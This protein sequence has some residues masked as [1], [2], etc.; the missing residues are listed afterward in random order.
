VLVALCAVAYFP[1]LTSQGLTNWQESARALAAR[2]MQDRGD[3]VVPTIDGRPYLAKP[4]MFYWYQ[5]ALGLALGGRVGELELR[6]SAALAGTA[7]VLATYFAGRRL[8][9]SGSGLGGS[10]DAAS[11]LRGAGEERARRG[12]LWGSAF[13]ATGILY[14][15]SSRVGELDIA[16]VAWT[17]LGVWGIF[18][19]WRA[20]R[21]GARA[22]W[23][24]LAALGCAGA[25]LTKGPVGL[26]VP[27]CAGFGGIVA[28]AA[29]AGRGASGARREARAGSGG[30][31]RAAAAG[32]W[33]ANPVVVM[34]SGVAALWAWGRG[35]EAR[36][37]SAE[38]VS[39]AAAMEAG[40]NL[41]LLS[42]E[43]VLENLESLSFGAGAGSVGMVLALIWL[44]R[45]RPTL[46]AGAWVVVLWVVASAVVFTVFGRGSPRYLTPV[47]PGVAL[48]AGMWMA[49]AERR[50]GAGTAVRGAGVA[51]VVTLAIVQGWWYGWG[52]ARYDGARSPRA[53]MGELL[54]PGLGVDRTA[55]HALDFWTP[56]LAFYADAPVVPVHLDGPHID[57]PHEEMTFA[58]F[59]RRVE[60][61]EGETVTLLVRASAAPGTDGAE[62]IERLA[63]LGLVVESIPVKAEYVIDGRRTAVRAVRVSAGARPTR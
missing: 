44:A 62:P 57:Y 8:L 9:R 20:D 23:L 50:P 47:W 43:T 45:R 22:A 51:A 33:R 30:R 31:W 1:G 48:L 28:H 60:E 19:S 21:A 58:A 41:V 42:R 6:L 39:R 46:P 38:A 26:I 16:L 14:V 35:V 27:A 34:G 24:A 25:S 56:A 53:F 54:S 49:D 12:A 13:L 7:G 61:R 32:L 3:W 37:G 17:V 36:L 10:A 18:E 52:R 29:Q 40:D 63:G 5:L 55:V 15:R 4:P 11:E 59:R 2:E